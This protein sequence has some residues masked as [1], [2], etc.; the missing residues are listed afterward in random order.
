[1]RMKAYAPSKSDITMPMKCIKKAK[2]KV[3]DVYDNKALRG[4]RLRT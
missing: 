4:S 2:P 3:K 1:M